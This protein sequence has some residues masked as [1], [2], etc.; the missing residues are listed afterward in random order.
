MRA[1]LSLS[2][3]L[4]LGLLSACDKKDEGEED[5]PTEQLGGVTTDDQPDNSDGDGGGGG[6]D[7]GDDKPDAPQITRSSCLAKGHFWYDESDVDQSDKAGFA[8]LKPSCHEDA[9]DNCP[10]SGEVIWA[11]ADDGDDETLLTQNV[12]DNGIYAWSSD[13]KEVYSPIRCIDGAG[14]KTLS[15]G[16]NDLDKLDIHF[17]RN[18]EYLDVGFNDDLVSLTLPQDAGE[19]LYN[20]D[21]SATQVDPSNLPE[22]GE[23]TDLRA[24]NLQVAALDLSG[25]PSLNSLEIA[26]SDVSSINL[27]QVPDLTELNISGTN[28]DVATLGLAGTNVVSLDAAFMNLSDLS[29]IP[30]TLVALNISN[31]P[32]MTLD[33]SGFAALESAWCV[34]CDLTSVTLPSGTALQYVSLWSNQLASIDLSGASG[35]LGVDLAMNALT[36]VDFSGNPSLEYI[37]LSD[38][39]LQ[40]DGVSTKLDLSLQANLY[41]LRLT[42]NEDFVLAIEEGMTFNAGYLTNDYGEIYIE[43]AKWDACMDADKPAWF[44]NGSDYYTAWDPDA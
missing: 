14:G 8:A 9:Q 20:L 42:G 39:D 5:S 38:N 25:M 41:S 17:L 10:S 13:V 2:T 32:L 33:L 21:I 43:S 37:D 24:N 16:S 34:D 18:L 36:A 30:N 3:I 27:S 15:I 12:D 31:N 29:A 1:L 4:A 11:F 19:S 23:L 40:Y 28:I 44:A 6:D 22:L 26:Y 7:G 35:L